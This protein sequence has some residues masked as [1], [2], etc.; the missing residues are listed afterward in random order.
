MENH[1]KIIERLKRDSRNINPDNPIP[2]EVLPD[3][4][5]N[6]LKTLNKVH[7]FSMHHLFAGLIFTI[8][9]SIGNS[10]RLRHKKDWN[11]Q[12]SF[13]CVI[14]GNPGE[15]KSH[16]LN[17]MLAPLKEHDALLYERFKSEKAAITEN[18]DSTKISKPIQYLTN[19]ATGE[20]I[21][22][23]LAIN[24]KGIGIAVD[25]YRTLTNG[26][27]MYRNNG[28]NDEEMFLSAFSNQQIKISR[29]TKEM[30]LIP[31][32]NINT[33][34]GIQPKMFFSTFGKSRLY[35]GFLDRHLIFWDP[36]P[37]KIKW[38]DLEVPLELTEKYKTLIMNLIRKSELLEDP[39]YLTFPDSVKAMLHRWQN[40]NQ[41]DLDFPY[42]ES[43]VIKL[44]EYVL[45][46]CIFLHII[47]NIESEELPL[48]IE[49]KT[50]HGATKLYSYFKENIERVYDLF[51]KDHLENLSENLRKVY[52]K[53]PM[54]AFKAGDGVR[55]CIDN[56]LISE[57][58]FYRFLKDDKLFRK[59]KHGE[60]MK[61]F[62][63]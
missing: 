55:I 53:L 43:A 2:I 27:N 22:E 28:G 50:V 1:R 41:K 14:V 45:R 3:L 56:K 29:V 31:N 6:L 5:Q 62:Y 8:A 60:Y 42:E 21:V 30:I 12:A 63:E 25:E 11:V 33:I 35:N 44:E 17:Y 18:A 58:S 19:N 10:I 37:Q 48:L 52:D 40:A 32:P 54:E 16:A 20:A 7:G 34:G 9:T 26:F 57:R 51:N 38:N 13:F 24:K 36:L 23:N 46:L 61:I 39:I 59:T 47:S 4:F 15:S 49:D